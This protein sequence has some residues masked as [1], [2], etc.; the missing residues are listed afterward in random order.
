[1]EMFRKAFLFCVGAVAVTYEEAAKSMQAQR[2][3]LHERF[4]KKEA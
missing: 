4:G 1:M 3:K 2:E